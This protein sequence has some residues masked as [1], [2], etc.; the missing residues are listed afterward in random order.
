MIRHVVPEGALLTVDAA[1]WGHVAH[2]TLLPATASR[3][4]HSSAHAQ[5]RARGFFSSTSPAAPE[6]YR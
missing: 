2:T 3:L 1:V 6:H 5:V 4:P